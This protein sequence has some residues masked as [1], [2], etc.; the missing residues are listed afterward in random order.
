MEQIFMNTEGVQTNMKILT[1]LLIAWMLMASV[2]GQTL[3]VRTSPV[4]ITLENAEERL[5]LTVSG[6]WFIQFTRNDWDKKINEKSY[7]L[8]PIEDSDGVV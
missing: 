7:N 2:F 1:L 5:N 3:T 6:K 8:Y 4:T